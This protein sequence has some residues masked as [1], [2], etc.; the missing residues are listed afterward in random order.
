MQKISNLSDFFALVRGA[1][2]FFDP[3]WGNN[4]DKLIALGS[5]EAFRRHGI[6]LTRSPKHAQAIVLNGG[7]G[8]TPRWGALGVLYNYVRS[9][10]NKM[11]VVL[12]SSWESVETGG[13]TDALSLPRRAPVFLFAREK[14]SLE[15]LYALSVKYK[16]LTV[17]LDHDMAF[18]LQD[19]DFL[20]RL[21]RRAEAKHIL[22][23]ERKDKEASPGVKCSRPVLISLISNVV[24]AGVRTALPLRTRVKIASLLAPVERLITKLQTGSYE[25]SA[26]YEQALQLVKNNHREHADLPVYVA[27][28]SLP[29]VCNFR[30]F[31]LAVAH[32][33]VVITTRLHVAI[34]A[35]L[36][37]K[38]TYLKEGPWHKIKGVYEYSLKE[39]GYVEMI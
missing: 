31:C 18:Q 16:N 34:L 11:I 37:G 20:A 12:P 39:F 32:A 8:M 9:Y 21:K 33:A 29:T 15:A 5:L 26:F 27:D 25:E 30:N 3:L 36:L 6:K 14:Y 17:G 19:T 28:V 4:G 10:P 23:V 38:P 22:V 13:L 24:P 2:I 7:G 35:A 1:R